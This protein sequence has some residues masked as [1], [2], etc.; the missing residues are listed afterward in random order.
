MY[1]D[2]LRY[3]QI[4]SDAVWPFLEFL[5]DGPKDKAGLVETFVV[6]FLRFHIIFVLILPAIP[7]G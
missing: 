4:W 6:R 7:R 5:P 1:S 2:V 3:S